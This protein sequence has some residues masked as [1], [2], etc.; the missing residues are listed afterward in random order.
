M[1]TPLDLRLADDTPIEPPSL[2]ELYQLAITKRDESPLARVLQARLRQIEQ[3]GHTA[4]ADDAAGVGKLVA[5]ARAKVLKTLQTAFRDMDSDL[6]MAG[7]MAMG[8]I[9]ALTTAEL[10]LLD[11]RIAQ[12]IATGLAAMDVID[13]ERA[14]R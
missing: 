12:A 1:S 13:R 5:V 2:R 8:R 10:D 7:D 4:A 6:Q 14:R 9:D 3:H 11:R